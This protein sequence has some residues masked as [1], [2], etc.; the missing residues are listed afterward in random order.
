MLFVIS[1]PVPPSCLLHLFLP[2]IVFAQCEA[3]L[4]SGAPCG[5]EDFFT[6][7]D[8]EV[9]YPTQAFWIFF[10]ETI[11]HSGLFLFLRLFRRLCLAQTV[12]TS[13]RWTSKSVGWRENLKYILQPVR[14][15]LLPAALVSGRLHALFGRDVMCVCWLL[16]SIQVKSYHSKNLSGYG[17]VRLDYRCWLWIATLSWRWI[18]SSTVPLLPKKRKQP[19]NP[20]TPN[21]CELWD[22]PSWQVQ[23]KLPQVCNSSSSHDPNNNWRLWTSRLRLRC[24]R[25]WLLSRPVQL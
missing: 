20:T 3:E 6:E 17:M 4:P 10:W 24:C 22:Q 8:P 9:G 19:P 18:V 15:I 12:H 25:K 16:A 21:K 14:K 1:P 5:Q 11:F 23:I 13:W 2:G 7:A